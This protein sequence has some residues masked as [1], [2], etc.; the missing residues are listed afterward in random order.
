MKVVVTDEKVPEDSSL[1]EIAQTNHVFNSLK[2]VMMMIVN[3]LL[4]MVVP[5]MTDCKDFDAKDNRDL[6]MMM[7]IMTMMMMMS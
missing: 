1:V 5:K 6:I 2:N 3:M 4:V 7:I